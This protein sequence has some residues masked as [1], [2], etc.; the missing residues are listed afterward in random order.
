[1]GGYKKIW[2]LSSLA[3]F[4]LS[5]SLTVYAEPDLADFRFVRLLENDDVFDNLDKIPGLEEGVAF[6][7]GAATVLNLN[8]P[9]A[10]DQ[11]V[12]SARLGLV[13]P[14]EPAKSRTEIEIF[15]P[16]NVAFDTGDTKPGLF[17]MF[18]YDTNE[19]TA[20]RQNPQSFLVPGSIRH[21]DVTQWG[22]KNARGMTL[23]PDSGTLFVLDVLPDGPDLAIIKLGH[24]RSPRGTSSDRVDLCKVVGPGRPR[25]IAFNPQNGHLYLFVP[26]TE[27]IIEVTRIG[28]LV[29]R[30]EI[31]TLDT[32]DL[33]GVIFSSS[34]DGTDDPLI[35]NLFVVSGGGAYGELSEWTLTKSNPVQK[36]DR[37]KQPKLNPLQELL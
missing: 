10:V 14:G 26:G 2:V 35:F 23:D 9:E 21:F 6:P 24:Q 31:P 17:S 5:L 16:I 29:D 8:L 33:Q 18:I 30:R 15:D 28:E 12:N 22:V 25:G 37:V 11:P 20:I 19:L 3:I 1:M 32:T 7:P 4:F 27:E 34:S 36:S 13:R